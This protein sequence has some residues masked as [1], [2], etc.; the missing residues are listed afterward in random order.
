MIPF[1]QAMVS[2]KMRRMVKIGVAVRTSYSGPIVVAND[3]GVHP[4]DSITI[5]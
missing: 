3:A 5:M 1:V 4:A 2:P